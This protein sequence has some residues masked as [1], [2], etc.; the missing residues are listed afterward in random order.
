MKKI[1]NINLSGRVIPIEDAAYETLQRYI[2]SLRRYFAAEEGRDEI[3]NDIESRIAELMNDKVRKGAEAVTESD[4]AE[5]INAM[6]RI[7]DFEQAEGAESTSATGGQTFSNA[8]TTGSTGKRFRGRL[9]RDAS[10]KILGGVCSGIASYMNVDPAIVRLLFAIITFGG[11]GFGIFLYILAWI[12]L[13]ARDLENFVG[14]RLFRNPEER[15][16]GGV[17]SGLAAY[18]N[19]EVWIFRLV[20]AGPLVL[21]IL[22]G[23]LNLID[24]SYHS[25]VF[26][27][28]F[29]GSFTGTFMLIYIVLWVVLPEA[30]SPF[31]RMEMRGET[32]DVNRIK[33]NVQ[34]NMTDIGARAQAWG[35]EV[36]Q[37]A[38]QWSARASQFANTRG[39][40][41]VAEVNQS[42]RT[43]GR[44]VGHIIGMLFKA[45]FLFVFGSIAFGLFVAVLVFTAGGLAQPVNN[46]LLD[47]FWQKLFLWG[48]LVFFLAVP[49][50]A[51]ITWIVRRLMKVRSQNRYLGWTF[52]GLWTVGWISLILF[53]A[54]ITKDFRNY[55]EVSQNISVAQPAVTKMLLRVDEPRVR[56][57]GTFDWI[58]DDNDNDGGWDL[59]EDSLRLSNVKMRFLKST[60]SLYHITLWR[61]SRGRNRADAA[62]RAE[63]IG[64]NIT[65]LNDALV[66]GSSYG[67]G[68]AQKFR[69]Q[70]VIVEIHVPVGHQ[71][72]FDESVQD[73]LRPTYYNTRSERRR[74]NYSWDRDWDFDEHYGANFELQTGV[75][76][77]MTESGKLEDLA[78]PA[79][80]KKSGVYEYS[81]S[82]NRKL[83]SQIHNLQQQKEQRIEEQRQKV[84]EENRKLER[85]QNNDDADD[86]DDQKTGRT[87]TNGPRKP[88]IE[89]TGIHTPIF[90]LLI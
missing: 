20:F 85:L 79:A 59:T 14:K 41:F 23:M 15:I 32:V 54:S 33:Q 11:F 77:T 38:E 57:S 18:F 13:P 16:L 12:I 68:R 25:D 29:I 89:T 69:A 31:E 73:K 50:V 70:Q 56:Y 80:S 37:S 46:F 42:G 76:Y 39:K 51:L 67:V 4:I 49:L 88:G 24:N 3:I 82:T 9:Y 26:P 44:G 60:D 55:D 48:T 81:D 28:F 71:L 87:K 1:I 62:A 40:T 86:N 66:L 72:R 7:E 61:Y 90:S 47:G 74:N 30:R 65:S 78:K 75:D 84:E 52:A 34:Q 2:E 63:K 35:K 45:F 36:R 6:G 53:A 27:N 58:N 5:I 43:V 17:A 19:R 8:H 21:N 22:F 10:D 64:Y 83:D